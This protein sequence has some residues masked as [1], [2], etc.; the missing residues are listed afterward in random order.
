[1]SKSKKYSNEDAASFVECE[2]L[3][4]AVQQYISGDEFED[5]HLGKL[6]N[7]ARDALNA[8]ERYL[9]ETTTTYEYSGDDEWETDDDEDDDE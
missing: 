2:G 7:D 8:L 3:D 5:T 9:S 4:Y 1:M 6:W